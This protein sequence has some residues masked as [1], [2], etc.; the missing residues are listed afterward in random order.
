MTSQSEQAL[1]D[2]LIAQ[3]QEMKYE[4]VK[5]A[6]EKDLLANLKIQLEKHNNIALTDNEFGRVLNHLNKGNIFDRAKILRDK[7]HLVRDDGTSAYIEF[8]NSREW[9]QN[10]FQ[11]TNQVTNEGSYKNRY[12]VTILINGLPLVQIELKRRGLDLKEAFNQ[13][14]RY[15]RHSYDASYGLFRYIQIFVISNGVNTKYYA[16]NHRQSFKFTSFWA[17]KENNKITDLAKFT[18][19][20]LERCHIANIIAFYTVLAETKTLMVLRPYQYYA[21]EAIID[22]VQN[23]T[24]GGYIWHTTGSG[25]TLTSFKASQILVDLPEI[26][27]VVFVVDRND[28]D[29]QTIRELNNFEEDCVDQTDNTRQL[30]KQFG[31]PDSKLIVKIG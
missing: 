5:I 21:V 11:V 14:N 6:D 27:K 23:S 20:Y 29:T 26:Y 17:D 1:E 24:K 13:V 30:V 25:K 22:R 12:D 16:N 7:M 15:Q 2:N 28:L 19:S 4:R 3:L 10:Q 31:N 9:C 8:F 18:E